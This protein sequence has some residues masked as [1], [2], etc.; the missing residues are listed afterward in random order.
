MRGGGGGGN[1]VYILHLTSKLQYDMCTS[2]FL[3]APPPQ[4]KWGD[5]IIIHF[6]YVNLIKMSV[7][8]KVDGAA[9]PP[10]FFFC[11]VT[12]V[13]KDFEFHFK[14]FRK[15]EKKNSKKV[16]LHQMVEVF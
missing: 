9:P 16:V 1:V 4:K 7:A 8:A 3:H 2:I 12:G 6:L 15:N 11:Y 10:F 14:S 13:D 5:S